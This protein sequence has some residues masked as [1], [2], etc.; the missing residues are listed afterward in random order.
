MYS[1]LGTFRK[2]PEFEKGGDPFDTADAEK[3]LWLHVILRAM[4]D[5]IILYNVQDSL[6]P[7]KAQLIGTT[8]KEDVRYFFRTAKF[9][10]FDDKN[11][12][13][14]SLNRICHEIFTDA[15]HA[16]KAIRQ[17]CIQKRGDETLTYTQKADAITFFVK[18]HQFVSTRKS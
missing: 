18:K 5:Y 15:D 13:Q 8:G 6:D 14:F 17:F 7:V 9:F 2:P 11:P 1:D 10:L 3:E 16:I 12:A 4:L